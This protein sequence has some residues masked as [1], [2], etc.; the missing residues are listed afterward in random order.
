MSAA[1]I[2]TRVNSGKGN[3]SPGPGVLVGSSES[4]RKKRLEVELDMI[5]IYKMISIPD[6][7]PT[8][9]KISNNI[10]N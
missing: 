2:E 3:A 7:G 9:L 6:T 10:V 1:L 5:N 8:F 4:C